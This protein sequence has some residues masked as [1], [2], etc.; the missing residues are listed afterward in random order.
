[1]T[2]RATPE[3]G[4]AFVT[5]ASS[6]I[7][8]GVAKELVRRGYK[9]A[10]TARRSAELDALAADAAGLAGAIVSYPGD[11]TDRAGMATLISRIEAREGPIILAFLNAGA[12][13][14]DE[15]GKVVGDG[16]RDTFDI[17]VGG[18]IN[19]LEPLVAA[20]RARGKG[21]I[22]ITAS[23]AGYGPL[24]RAAAYGAS[25]AALINMAG[26]LR[27]ALRRAGINVQ[28]VNPGFVRTALTDNSGFRMPF[29]VAVDEA[30]RRICGGFEH[31]GFEISFPRRM[32]WIAKGLNMLPWSAY[33]ALIGWRSAR[34]A[35][36]RAA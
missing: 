24:P 31:K 20:M 12:F 25:K 7:G 3:A 19:C 16:F 33:F 10:A 32:S 2:F 8:R 15:A 1:V 9:V 5:G 23:I 11:V 13:V 27:F 21:Q 17:N 6:G 22:A 14:P 18:T 34:G 35:K 4:I 29:L 30:A 26:G 28:V 36:R